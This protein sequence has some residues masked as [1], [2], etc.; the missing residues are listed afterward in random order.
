MREALAALLHGVSRADLA[1]RSAAITALY[2]AG[3]G[4]DVAIADRLDALAYAVA[5][6][7]ATCAAVAE[8]LRRLREAAPDLAPA[9]LLDLGCGAGAAT[10]AARQAFASL[11]EARLIDRNPAMLDL[12]RELAAADGLAV[13]ARRAGLDEAAGEA[14][15]VTL[16]YVLVESPV[17]EAAKIACAAFAR[18]RA[19]LVLVEPGT[20]A[21]FERLRVAR[22]ALIEAGAH[23][24]APCPHALAC[25]VAAPDWR[26]FSV[27]V[28]RSRD[29]LATK[30]AEVPYED[31]PFMYLAL[32][33]APVAPEGARILARPRRDRTGVALRL[34]DADGALRDL[35]IPARDRE[36]TRHAR[37][38]DEGDVFTPR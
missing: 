15:L 12:A 20:P 23:L 33:R 5:R 21:G 27:R 7:P 22:A 19:A 26:H 13:E 11:T 4:S 36:A 38:L 29:H 24:A 2:R 14:D 8:A 28:Q 25:P 18:A 6:M 31:E 3:R 30:R 10:R 16:A 9:S 32:T 17:A 1:R 35:V 34:C 37:R